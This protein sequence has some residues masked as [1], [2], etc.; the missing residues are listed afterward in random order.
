MLERPVGLVED[1]V[2]LEGSFRHPL[3]LAAV[4]FCLS[5]QIVHAITVLQSP[6]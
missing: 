2:P 3:D 5:P 6:P 4:E 1:P